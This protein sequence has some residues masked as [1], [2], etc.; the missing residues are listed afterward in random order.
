[1]FE[2]ASDHA[3][4]LPAADGTLWLARRQPNGDLQIS[5]P[6]GVREGPRVSGVR[7]QWSA[8]VDH[9]GIPWLVT[10]EEGRIHARRYDNGAW[11]PRL[12]VST[13]PETATDPF[14]VADEYA[15]VWIFWR[16]LDSAELWM[17]RM[18]PRSGQ[19]TR[20]AAA[21]AGRMLGAATREGSLHVL[22]ER[23]GRAFLATGT[24]HGGFGPPVEVAA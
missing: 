13:R 16:Y 12:Q 15:N 22:F 10:W 24:E 1:M 9:A 21:P 19:E 2:T 14:V 20:V 18:G 4:L 11:G 17:C 8:T 7:N 23:D 6:S 3:K 5:D